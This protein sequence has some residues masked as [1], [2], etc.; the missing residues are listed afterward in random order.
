MS[1][2]FINDDFTIFY[3]NKYFCDNINVSQ[4]SLNGLPFSDLTDFNLAEYKS[5]VDLDNKYTQIDISFNKQ[6][7]KEFFLL[8]TKLKIDMSEEETS[9]NLIVL[10]LQ[11]TSNDEFEQVNNPIYQEWIKEAKNNISLIVYTFESGYGPKPLF[12]V[13]DK[14]FSRSKDP[15]SHIISKIGLYLMT[16][17]AQGTT[18][19]TGLFGPLPVSGAEF[20]D[21]NAILYA[22]HVNDKTQKDP[23]TNGQ[24][25]TLVTIFYPKLYERLILNRRRI[26]TI[27]LNY[28][29][30]EDISLLNYTTIE[31]MYNEIFLIDQEVRVEKSK[32]TKKP[33]KKRGKKKRKISKTL[34]S[35]I[36][37]LIEFQNQIR[38]IF[39]LDTI[40][41]EIANMTEKIVDFKLLAI[42]G[43]D[44]FGKEL[45]ILN[46]RGYYD[47]K[48][49]NIRLSIVGKA[50]SVAAKAAQ[51]LKTTYAPDISKIDYYLNLDNTIRSDL[52]VPIKIKNELLGLIIIESDKINAFSNDDQTI[53]EILAENTANVINQHRNE[54]IQH[55]LNVLLNNILH[56]DTFEEAIEEIAKFAEILINFELFC[57]VDTKDE[58][59][60]FISHRGYGS[61]KNL[62][63][64]KRDDKKF[65]ISQAFLQKEFV[66][67]DNLKENQKI[68][69]FKVKSNI[70]AEYC[71]PI[72]DNDKNVV[73]IINVESVNP[74]NRHELVIFE[75]LANY[76]KLI[77][78]IFILEN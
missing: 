53:V 41:N 58:Y 66:Y 13:N 44:K 21:I 32:K 63:V 8:E 40:I 20:E 10:I 68:P 72:L 22:L 78:R 45:Y 75:T 43:Y 65:F 3:A 71:I 30:V 23:R 9:R 50:K 5:R 61:D 70:S 54:I 51:T 60:K 56:A 35:K 76:T 67:I 64:F 28:L 55:D 46:T 36:L 62:P 4:T 6:D 59:V 39:D 27:A 11:E 42:F 38:D 37:E 47:Y 34:D 18:Q 2:L 49:K 69:Y 14:L 74:L 73:G 1:I 17:I 15:V 77:Y 19:S 31:K 48:I 33:I 24:R 29:R 16:A 7:P 57:I 52:A 26:R 25:Y 12:I